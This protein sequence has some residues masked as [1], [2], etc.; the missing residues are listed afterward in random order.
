MTTIAQSQDFIAGSHP[1]HRR[2]RTARIEPAILQTF[3]KSVRCYDVQQLEYV[4]YTRFVVAKLLAETCD[5]LFEF[6]RESIQDRTFGGLMTGLDGV[7]DDRDDYV[8]FATAIAFMLGAANFDSMSG[9]F[10]ARFTVNHTD[11]SDSYLRQAYRD[12]TLHTDGTYVEEPTD[13]LLMMKFAERNAIGGESR[14]IHLDDWEDLAHFA[15]DPIGSVALDYS[16]PPSK[17]VA[18][19]VAHSTFF[20]VD[21]SWGISFIDQFAQP[22]TITDATYL[23]SLSDSL[24]RSAGTVS[25]PVSVGNLIVLNNAFWLHG[26]SSFE[27]NEQLDR[28]LLR[29]RGVFA[30]DVDRR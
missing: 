4:P 14:V 27:R 13:Y 23:A 17:K 8:R 12:M 16:A 1:L 11:K 10:Y 28:E 26:R 9:K 6:V 25:L 20:K 22:A 3:L 21:G 30:P 29:I 19:K 2:I 18:H 7:T 5:G 24:E 15:D